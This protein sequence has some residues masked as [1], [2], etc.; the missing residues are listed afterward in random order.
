[1][2]EHSLHKGFQLAL[3]WRLFVDGS[4]RTGDQAAQ[5]SPGPA[6]AQ[7]WSASSTFFVRMSDAVKAATSFRAA[8]FSF[9]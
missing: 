6:L 1:M 3:G 7:L 5:I 8:A 9:G 4:A 2:T